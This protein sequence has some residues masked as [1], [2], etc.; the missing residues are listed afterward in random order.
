MGR[1]LPGIEGRAGAFAV[2][3]GVQQ[4]QEIQGTT[5]DLR[6]QYIT[7][8]IPTRRWTIPTP[9][10]PPIGSAG[11]GP[12]R[13]TSVSLDV[14]FFATRKRE[15]GSGGDVGLRARGCGGH[16]GFYPWV[17]HVDATTT[18]TEAESRGRSAI[19]AADGAAEWQVGPG[20]RGMST[21]SER[22]VCAWGP[23]GRWT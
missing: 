1:C 23:L 15:D 3:G 13:R 4:R 22:G 16:A 2:R 9:H 14:G 8:V 10:W 5:T 7:P 17:S 6:A 18:T 20:V 11:T 21:R 19:T 12:R